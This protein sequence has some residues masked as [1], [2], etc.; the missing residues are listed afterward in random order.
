M[1]SVRFFWWLFQYCGFHW[2][3]DFTFIIGCSWS[4]RVLSLRYSLWPI[5][6]SI[7]IPHG[8]LLHIYYVWLPACKVTLAPLGYSYYVLIPEKWFIQDFTWMLL[9]WYLS[10]LF[11]QSQLTSTHYFSAAKA[12]LSLWWS[13]VNHSWFFIHNWTETTNS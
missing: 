4:P 3:L 13:L 11:F 5:H 6:V 9:V 8:R 10:E 2:N 1:L 12:L 7:A